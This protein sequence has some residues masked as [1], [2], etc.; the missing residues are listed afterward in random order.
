MV[1]NFNSASLADEK[2]EGTNLAKT[3]EAKPSAYE[4]IDY[5]P[6]IESPDVFRQIKPLKCEEG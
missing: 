4:G 5:S 2:H 6:E 1:E 3:L